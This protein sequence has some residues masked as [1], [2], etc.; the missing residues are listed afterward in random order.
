VNLSFDGTTS[1]W[2]GEWDYVVLCDPNE[3][4]WEED[5]NTLQV[6]T[7]GSSITLPGAGAVTRIGYAL[8]GWNTK[9]DGT[10]INYSAGESFTLNSDIILYAKWN[11][12]PFETMSLDDKLVWLQVYAENGGSYT[13]ELTGNESIAPQSLSYDGKSNITITLRGVGANRTISLSSNGSLFRVGSGVTLVLDSNVTLQGNS[14]NTD[15]LVRVN[16]GGTLIMNN[17]STITGNTAP[18]GGGVYVD[19]GTFTMNGGTISGNTAAVFGGGVN[20]L[21]GTFTMNGGTISGNTAAASYG[22]GGGV[23]VGAGTF[24][25]TGGTINGNN[26]SNTNRNMVKD[27]SGAEV[28]DRGHAVYVDV[29]GTVKRR[30]TTAGPGVNL[31]VDGIANPPTFGGE[32]EN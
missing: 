32:W 12:V 31:S 20:V 15:S 1:I 16:S 25:K 29:G 10:G 3:G 6:V 23:Y 14:S 19:G 2:S 24:T 26:A 11:P 22:A 7:P 9:A 13:I 27:D 5:S 18:H 4:E 21:G 28:N 17:V 8:G 30:E